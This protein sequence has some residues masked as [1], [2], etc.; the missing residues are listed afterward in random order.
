MADQSDVEN[1][2]CAAVL[3]A[4][5]PGAGQFPLL[6]GQPV[7]VFRGSAPAAGLTIDRSAGVSEV[8][9]SAVADTLHNTTRWNAP[10][11][12]LSIAAGLT[13]TASGQTAT[14]AGSAVAGEL[15]GVLVNDQPF[16]YA[17][18]PGDSAAL[19]AAAV[20][21]LVRASQI[22]WVSGASLTIPA[23]V[24]LVA[25]TAGVASVVQ[26]LGRQEQAFRL[27]VLSPSPAAR[28]AVCAAL[29]PPLLGTAFVALADGTGARIRF[30]QAVSSDADQVASIYQ[31]DL[32]FSV[33]Y[34]TT[35]TTQSAVMLF[36]DSDYNTV[37][38]FI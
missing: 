29:L 26:E 11:S 37:P 33:E 22:V 1:A 4:A 35:V 19:V 28:D 9:V 21:N 30:S 12:L 20:A 6:G 34:G 15:A 36:G 14:F 8:A 16:V 18:Q 2:L 17:A 23:A 5:Q 10:A 38:T 27:S 3:A 25:R 24:M 32:L 13:A 31:R 7:R